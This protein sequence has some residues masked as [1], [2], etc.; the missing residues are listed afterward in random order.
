[1][2]NIQLKAK[3]T[4]L[5]P[6]AQR[7]VAKKHL[8]YLLDNTLPEGSKAYVAGGAP[9]DWHHGWGCRDIDIFYS[10]PEEHRQQVTEI[11][12]A[13]YSTVSKEY[14]NY[15]YGI[16]G[17]QQLLSIHEY[18]AKLL[19]PRAKSTQYTKVQLIQTK[20]DPLDV[21][22][23]FPIS[24]SRIWMDR[25]GDINCDIL[26]ANSWNGRII[27]E[28]HD[29]QGWNYVYL[30]K[31]LGRFSEYTF[32]PLNWKGRRSEDETFEMPF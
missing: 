9:R 28:V 19:S 14:G 18:D 30:D 32:M 16:N 20:L 12:D 17:H 4:G 31:I 1:M 6:I 29:K 22:Q 5:L 10:V 8:N 2:H 27:H 3:S 7:Q 13:E 15:D 24:L 21:I 26:Y 23:D 11:M 25:T